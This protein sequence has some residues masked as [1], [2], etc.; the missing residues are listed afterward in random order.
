MFVVRRVSHRAVNR[1]K[2]ILPGL[3]LGAVDGVEQV[4]QVSLDINPTV[5]ISLAKLKLGIQISLRRVGSSRTLIRAEGGSIDPEISSPFHRTT[6]TG[7]T[8]RRNRRSKHSF[9]DPE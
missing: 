8:N 2:Q 9:L 1:S 4:D 6:R 5:A 3:S 7:L